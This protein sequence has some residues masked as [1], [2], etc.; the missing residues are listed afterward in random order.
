MGQYRVVVRVNP[1]SSLRFLLEETARIAVKDYGFSLPGGLAAEILRLQTW[2]GAVIFP[3]YL[4]EPVSE[5]VVSAGGSSGYGPDFKIVLPRHPGASVPYGS[6]GSGS[7]GTA[8]FSTASSHAASSSHA[9]STTH[10]Y[11][12][13]ATLEPPATFIDPISQRR[14]PGPGS[15]VQGETVAS[16]PA[17]ARTAPQAIYKPATSTAPTSTSPSSSLPTLASAPKRAPTERISAAIPG[18]VKLFLGC[19]KASA[20]EAGNR[21]GWAWARDV[22][23]RFLER[24]GQGVGD[25]YTLARERGLVE[26]RRHGGNNEA[27]VRIV[28]FKPEQPGKREKSGKSGFSTKGVSEWERTLGQERTTGERTAWERTMV[29]GQG[30]GKGLSKADP[31]PARSG[32]RAVPTDAA[33]SQG[34]GA[35]WPSLPNTSTLDPKPL[36]LDE[37]V[38]ILVE[39]MKTRDVEVGSAKEGPCK[40]SGG[41]G[42]DDSN[43]SFSDLGAARAWRSLSE[44]AALFLDKT[45][46]DVAAAL[47][48]AE[49]AGIVERRGGGPDDPLRL[50]ESFG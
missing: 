23:R 9:G 30:E 36:G 29:I 27:Q 43:E 20:L 19:I 34:E 50:S 38:D 7:T 47:L 11:P 32:T 28:G 1:G 2:D 16:G 25:N 21:E 26:S 14:D 13:R 37:A 49:K 40:M 5:W 41:G 18:L 35:S 45:G 31:T 8:F 44:V 10:P 6:Y 3:A 46:H 48:A 15:Q 4:D 22:D 33:G 12:A 39:L 42:E 17:I 24:A